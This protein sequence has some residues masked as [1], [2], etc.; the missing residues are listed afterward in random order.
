MTCRVHTWVSAVLRAPASPFLLLRSYGDGAKV[1]NCALANLLDFPAER[2]TTLWA[3]RRGDK[4]IPTSE[5]L[6][7]IGAFPHGCITAVSGRACRNGLDRLSSLAIALSRS[8]SRRAI[9][10]RWTRSLVRMNSNAPAVFDE[11]EADGR[12]KMTFPRARRPEQQ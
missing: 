11:T 3:G 4:P 8:S 1:K 6:E 12:R 2:I 7:I 10:R 5:G 9:R